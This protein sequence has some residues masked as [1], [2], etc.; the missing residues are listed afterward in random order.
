MNDLVSEENV[1]LNPSS[2]TT[3][4]NLVVDEVVK[5]LGMPR[6]ILPPNDEISMALM[7]LPRELK[8]IPP[9]LRN[10]FIAKACIASS[11]GLFDGA[12]IYVWNCVIAE[13]RSRV[14]SFGMEMIAQIS[15]SS[16][17]DNFLDKIQD[18]DLLDLCYQLNIIDEQGHFFLQQCREVRNNA[19]IAHPSNI[20][21]DDRELV[22]FISR[23]C[24]YGLSELA[25]SAGIDIKSLNAVLSGGQ[26]SEALTHFV[27]IL[28]TTFRSQQT[29]VF[30]LLY[31]N[32]IDSSKTSTVRS[33]ALAIA[34]G[35][36]ELLSENHE[37]IIELLDKHNQYLLSGTDD[38]RTNSKK[39]FEEIGQLNSL[40]EV[41]KISSF[42]KAI[43]NLR[44]AHYGMNNFY[45]EPPFAE[46]L[47]ELSEQINPIPE[48]IIGKYVQVNLD[49]YVG[50]AYGVSWGAATECEKMLKNLTPKGIENLIT[51][52]NSV[53]Q[54]LG[55]SQK[56]R[57]RN[58][59]DYYEE[60]LIPFPVQKTQIQAL[61]S[62]F[63]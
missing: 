50:N 39:F 10:Q 38:Q 7:L 40:S 29:L 15:G 58:L 13:L 6:D 33:N 51:R 24:K 8:L 14:S 45:N 19:S 22:S 54:V 5:S 31:S 57:I 1:N 59:L 2:L 3:Q 26:D 55:E 32:Y 30:K 44:T 63:V 25:I 34:K 17:P 41:E 21:I 52:L 23:C 53:S 46:R 49:C 20:S 9:R 28:K 61:K 4:G 43:N 60:S 12:I 16:K 62:R 47:Q 56:G 18:V 36:S 27:S 48:Q 37:I 42:S 11:V 35:A